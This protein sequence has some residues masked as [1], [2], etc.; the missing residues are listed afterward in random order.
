ME[1]YFNTVAM[2]FGVFGGVI[3][4]YLGGMDAILHAILFLVV[5]DYITGLAKAWKQKKISSEVGFIGLLKKIMIF[6]VIAV[7]V[8]I[9]KLT[10]N[11]IPLREVVIMFYIAN[12]GISLLENISE[13]V[14]LPDKLKDYFIQIR[15]SNERGENNDIEGH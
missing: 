4:S 11:N 10:N 9:E 3:V 13:F 8:E 6:V 7:A 5:I 1:K 2:T 14:P 15:D 12:E